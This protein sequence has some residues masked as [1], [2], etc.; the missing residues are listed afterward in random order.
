[1]NDA[2]IKVQ[3]VENN[4]FV[5]IELRLEEKDIENEDELDDAS[6]IR[7]TLQALSSPNMWIGNTGAT[8]HPTKHRQGGINS[9]PLTSRTRGIHGQSMKPDVEVDLPGIYCDKNGKEQY[10]VKLHNI[11]VISESLYKFCSIT[12]LMKKGHLVK[13]NKKDGITAQ[14]GG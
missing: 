13:V 3:V 12:R 11:D 5:Q 10:A 8:K 2:F 6:Q 14:K 1:M 4:A 9:Q 7:P